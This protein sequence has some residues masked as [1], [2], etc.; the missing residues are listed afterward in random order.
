MKVLQMCGAVMIALASLMVTTDRTI[1][2]PVGTVHDQ[3]KECLKRGGIWTLLPKSLNVCAYTDGG[4]SANYPCGQCYYPNY[5]DCMKVGGTWVRAATTPPPFAYCL[6]P[7]NGGIQTSTPG[8]GNPGSSIGVDCGRYGLIPNGSGGC[9]R[10]NGGA[11][12]SASEENCLSQNE[13]LTG[14]VTRVDPR[15][16]SFTVMAEGKAV[17]FVAG[18]LKAGLPKVGA[19]IDVTYTQTKGGQLSATAFVTR[20]PSNDSNN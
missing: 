18:T 13:R 1:A 10:P 16:K 15:T 12:C 11:P 19:T 7:N 20:S 9:M 2:G 4:T 5:V 14:K 17:T 3:A 6:L 8:E